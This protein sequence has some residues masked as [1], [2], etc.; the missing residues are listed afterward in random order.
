MAHFTRLVAALLVGFISLAAASAQQNDKPQA[1]NRPEFSPQKTLQ[2]AKQNAVACFAGGQA[3]RCTTCEP[4]WH[5]SGTG[6]GS[7]QPPSDTSCDK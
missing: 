3:L 4:G 1:P 7:C 6:D 2:Q 5:C